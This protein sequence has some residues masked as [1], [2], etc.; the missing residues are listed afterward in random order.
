MGRTYDK[1]YKYFK[2]HNI[3]PLAVVNCLNYGHPKSA[4]GDLVNTVNDL[5]RKGK[6]DN[7]PVI[8]GNVSL[9]NSTD[10]KN[11]YPTPVLVMVGVE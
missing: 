8:G 1:C 2:S 10:G 9:Y 7:V 11:I 4:L 5:A 3:K 6:E